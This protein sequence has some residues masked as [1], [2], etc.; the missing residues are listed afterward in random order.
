MKGFWKF[1]IAVIGCEIVGLISTPFTISA[2]PAWYAHLNKPFFAP[3]NWLF[4]PAWTTLY[5][6]MG[7]AAFIVWQKG[8]KTK[9]VKEALSYFLLQLLF[10]FVWSIFFFGLRSPILGLIDILIMLLAINLTII[11]FNKVSKIASYIMIPYVLWVTFATILNLAIV[12][13]N[14]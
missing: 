2:I 6:L 9:K 4:G 10:N 14:R 7:L 12:L 8:T 11:S 3:P 1:I 13:L 5:F